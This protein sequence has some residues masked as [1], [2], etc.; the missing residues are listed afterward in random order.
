MY[1][2]C[3]NRKVYL[4]LL[5]FLAVVILS[6]SGCG[7]ETSSSAAKGGSP[8]EDLIRNFVQAINEKDTVAVGQMLGTNITYVEK[9]VDGSQ[10][11]VDQKEE[12][13]KLLIDKMDNDTIMSITTIKNQNGNNWEID[14]TI[15]DYI[16]EI[17]GFTQGIGYHSRFTLE[18]S[19]ISSIEFERD[20]EDE[21]LMDRKMEGIIGVVVYNDNGSVRI[22]ECDSGLP[23]EKAGLLIEDMI[24]AVDGI[25]IEE[26]KYGMDEVLY[27]MR[28]QVGDKIN[29]TINRNGIVF[30]LEIERVR[31]V[32]LEGL[33]LI[34]QYENVQAFYEGRINMGDEVVP[35]EI[36]G[37]DVYCYTEDA[38]ASAKGY[39]FLEE[40]GKL[41]M[42][43]D[44]CWFCVNEDYKNVTPKESGRYEA[45]EKMRAEFLLRQT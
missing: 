13:I 37:K 43:K 15:G 10:Y 34:N 35:V 18:G 36:R 3:K 5:V 20:Q 11:K 2:W 25:R 21:K 30:D 27:R 9:Y 14:G 39:F 45:A 19:K 26:M 1:L 41:Y 44:G 24:E 16:T 32:S 28:G 23:A 8:Q 4:T 12:T 22:K 29:L 31:D 6:L 17:L 7:E 38:V 33:L 40:M 42:V